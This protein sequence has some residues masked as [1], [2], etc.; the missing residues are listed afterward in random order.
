M[1][2]SIGN[3]IEYAIMHVGT[4]YG[5]LAIFPFFVAMDSSDAWAN[6]AE[7]Y[8]DEQFQPTVVAGV[9]PDYFSETG[10]LWG[11]PLYHWDV[12]ASNGY[13]WWMETDRCSAAAL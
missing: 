4:A 3:G 11:N 9:P 1:G 6:P 8:L 2:S 7:F 10:Q 13:A 5:S 12:M